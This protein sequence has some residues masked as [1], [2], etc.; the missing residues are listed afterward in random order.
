MEC[1]YSGLKT[2]ITPTAGPCLSASIKKEE[3]KLV[4]VI[5]NSKSMEHR[6][7]EAPKLIDW[8]IAKISKITKSNLKYKTKKNLLKKLLPNSPK[9]RIEYLS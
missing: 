5:L 3:F 7:I 9:S 6:W 8:T 1:G 4:V 2:G